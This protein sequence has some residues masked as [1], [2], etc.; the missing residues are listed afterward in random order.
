ME[1]MQ[2]L[3]RHRVALLAAGR[4]EA[5]P[6]D[7]RPASYSQ[8]IAGCSCAYL[9]G[10]R[11]IAAANPGDIDE[12]GATC[13]P[14]RDFCSSSQARPARPQTPSAE[15][16]FPRA[17]QGVGRDEHQSVRRAAARWPP[18]AWRRASRLP[19]SPTRSCICLPPPGHPR[20]GGLVAVYPGRNAKLKGGSAAGRTLMWSRRSAKTGRAIR[21]R[22]WK[23]TAIFLRARGRG[24][25]GRRC[26]V[27]R[28]AWCACANRITGRCAR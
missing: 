14:A 8:S 11:L 7:A 13:R 23:R 28:H 17:V 25:Q 24:R 16:R 18:S 1:R 19:G 6:Y 9:P 21:S 27:G 26:D 22:S 12:Q 4:L 15:Q 5:A 2:T 3:P 20:E 10:A